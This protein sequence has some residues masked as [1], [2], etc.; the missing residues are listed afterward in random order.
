MNNFKKMAEPKTKVPEIASKLSARE[1]AA[2]N[3]KL[4]RQPPSI[5]EIAKDTSV[6]FAA[7]IKRLGE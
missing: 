5:E 3:A 4:G 1:I 2:R 7:T 6:R